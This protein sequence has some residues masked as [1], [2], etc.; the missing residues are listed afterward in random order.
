MLEDVS[1]KQM[2]VTRTNCGTYFLR[3]FVCEG[4]YEARFGEA[5]PLANGDRVSPSFDNM[6]FVYT[7]LR[8]TFPP[9]LLFSA[10]GRL[11]FGFLFVQRDPRPLPAYAELEF[12][13]EPFR[14]VFEHSVSLLTS[15][16]NFIP[17]YSSI[18]LI[19]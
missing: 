12:E 15:F 4:E 3:L 5:R 16:K 10:V 9:S 11:S 14:F 2:I 8:L 18:I 1:A 19:L 7:C 13:F 17:Y 6:T